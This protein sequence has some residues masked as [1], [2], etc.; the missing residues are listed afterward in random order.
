M[1]YQATYCKFLNQ[2]KQRAAIA[3]VTIERFCISSRSWDRVL[4]H[5]TLRSLGLLETRK[6]QEQRCVSDPLCGRK[7]SDSHVPLKVTDV[8]ASHLTDGPST[9]DLGPTGTTTLFKRYQHTLKYIFI[10]SKYS[11]A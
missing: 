7:A 5:R 2:E 6:S 9:P 3:W 10:R 11:S 1:S 4:N 8:R